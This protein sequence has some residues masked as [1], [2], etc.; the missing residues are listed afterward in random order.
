[1]TRAV[2]DRY[3]RAKTAAAPERKI[4]IIVDLVRRKNCRIGF[5]VIETADVPPDGTRVLDGFRVPVLVPKSMPQRSR[6]CPTS[7]LLI[8]GE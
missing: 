4:A 1:L 6:A 3:P 8:L 7:T 2:F 5:V